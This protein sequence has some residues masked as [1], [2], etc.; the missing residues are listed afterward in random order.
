MAGGAGNDVYIV[1]SANDV[2]TEQSGSG[3]DEIR[4][5]LGTYSIAALANVENLTATSSSLAGNDTLTG[6]AGANVITASTSDST[7]VWYL[8]G[9][10][11]NDTIYGG[12]GVNFLYGG[13]GVDS[14]YSVGQYGTNYLDG[15]AGADTM[16]GG[17]SD[18][19]Y[20]VDNAL[21]VVD[22]PNAVSGGGGT[23]YVHTTLQTYTLG[24]EIE[25][26]RYAGTLS[27][28]GTGNSLNNVMYGGD[29]ATGAST[30]YGGGGNDYLETF[31]G[32]DVLNGGGGADTLKGG[33]GDD[34]YAVDNTGDIVTEL[35]GNGTDKV[36]AFISYTLGATLENLT[37]LG[38]NAI[39]GT[40]NAVANTIIGNG[41]ANAITGAGGADTLTGGLGADTFYFNAAVHSTVAAND[42][43][44]DFAHLSDRMGLAVIDANTG[45]A[46]DQQFNFLAA[47]GAAFTGTAGQLRYLASG[48][49][50]LV[51]GDVNGDG[52]A[53]L[54]I[55]LNGTLT[56]TAS[57]FI[58]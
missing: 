13:D 25:A 56:L 39:N 3:I 42:I 36:Q 22:E 49:N 33:A 57:D 4:T 16:H 9:Q 51:Q 35:A 12:S 8:Q 6:N 18:D 48:A 32:N 27:F 53:D 54:Q 45:L 31:I 46:G 38:T 7:D 24:A 37:L 58:L 28:T 17:A 47:K 50:T 44:T 55:Q 15:G 40:G 21:D 19:A 43:I 5:A 34:T 23:D 10:A 30:L 29:G 1:D 14:L 41:A 20:Y 2:V 52:V 26:L 11:G